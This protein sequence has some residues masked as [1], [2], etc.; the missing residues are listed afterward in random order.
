[1]EKLKIVINGN[2]D[3]AE[4]AKEYFGFLGYHI[5]NENRNNCYGWSLGHKEGD[6]YVSKLSFDEDKA[7]LVTVDQLKDLVV[8]KRND[9]G[10]ATHESRFYCYIGLSDGWYYFDMTVRGWVKSTSEK[11][12]FYE[13]LNPIEKKEMK[14][15]LVKNKN[16]G[17]YDLFRKYPDFS[18]ESDIEIPEGAEVAVYY[19]YSDK[20]FFWKDAGKTHWGESSRLRLD[21]YDCTANMFTGLDEFLNE[22]DDQAAIIWKRENKKTIASAVESVNDKVA[23]A[24]IARQSDIG[25]KEILECEP[26]Q[27]T[28]H[29]MKEADSIIAANIEEDNVNHPSHYASSEIECIDAMRAM[30]GREQ[31]IGYLRGNMLKYQWRY[32]KK[33]GI[34]DLKKSEWYLNKL[35]EVENE[36]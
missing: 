26:N 27:K 8:L 24:E 35:L 2:E 33:N 3:I 5:S 19:K 17:A 30:L 11:P 4:K 18:G 14:E 20:V 9:V 15:Y 21:W 16:T 29:A 34:E 12:K 10:D 28:I 36:L 13:R 31:F 7:R 25:F 22:W 32:Q 6:Y 23:S 1:M